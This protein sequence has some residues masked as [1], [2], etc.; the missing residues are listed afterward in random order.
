M[1]F[2]ATDLDVDMK[3]LIHEHGLGNIVQ[4]AFF[5]Q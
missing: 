1:Y 5:Y 2:V 4:R 3:A